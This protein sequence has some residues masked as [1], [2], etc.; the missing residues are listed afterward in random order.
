[1]AVLCFSPPDNKLTDLS[2][3]S[4]SPANSRISITFPFISSRFSPLYF[5]GRE[6]FSYT[7][8]SGISSLF[9]GIMPIL[10][11]RKIRLF[12][13]DVFTCLSLY[14]IFPESQVSTPPIILSSVDLPDPFLPSIT[15]TSPSFSSR[16]ISFKT[17]NEAPSDLKL[18]DTFS[19]INGIFYSLLN[20]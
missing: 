10:F 4:D 5:N 15:V 20:R 14:I 2:F 6:T 8:N 9:C 12:L 7:L 17:S 18:F 16:F 11:S 1:M 13:S 3:I 19:I